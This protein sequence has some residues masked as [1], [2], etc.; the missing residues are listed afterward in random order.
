MDSETV[1]TILEKKKKK[2]RDASPLWSVCGQ[3]S[4]VKAS[5]VLNER[6]RGVPAYEKLFS[7]LIYK[8]CFSFVYNP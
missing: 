4:D 6:P 1:V 7:L 8:M 2:I 3:A 5:L